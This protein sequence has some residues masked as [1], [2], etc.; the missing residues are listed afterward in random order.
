MA[1]CGNPDGELIAPCVPANH[2]IST[3]RLL[4]PANGPYKPL[5]PEYAISPL[6]DQEGWANEYPWRRYPADEWAL[7]SIGTRAYL[8]P[9]GTHMV[10]ERVDPQGTVSSPSDG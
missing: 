4:T 3:G 8:F 7:H 1:E 2:P 6:P 10:G 5:V 9:L